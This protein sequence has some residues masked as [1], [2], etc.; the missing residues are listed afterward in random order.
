MPKR[1][2]QSDHDDMVRTL[3]S[4][5]KQNQHTDVKADIEGYTQPALLHWETTQQGHIPDVTSTRGHDFLFEV[6]TADSINDTHT[7]DQWKLFSANAKQH[8]KSF[9][10]VVPKGSEAEARQRAQLLGVALLDVWT[11][12]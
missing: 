6:E 4:H 10:V 5:L 11:V 3:A 1:R 12:G 9:V 8:S 2:S 7:Q